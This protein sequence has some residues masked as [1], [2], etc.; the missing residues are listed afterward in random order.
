MRQVHQLV[1]AAVVAAA[2]TVAGVP[3]AATAEVPVG[4]TV[5]I[6]S[7]PEAASAGST[8]TFAFSADVEAT[9][10]CGL[11]GAELAPC[12]SPA[13]YAALAD[14]PHLFRVVATD[15]QGVVGAP[16]EVSWV[17]DT[18]APET[19]LVAAPPTPTESTTASFAFASTDAGAEFE[20]AVDGESFTACDGGTAAVGPLGDGSHTFAVRAAD[21]AGNVD[22]SPAAWKWTIDRSIV[23][24]QAPAVGATDV[25]PFTFV[26]VLFKKPMLASSFTTLTFTLWRS[27]GVQVP[28]SPSYNSSTGVATLAPVY[29]LDYSTTYRVRV[30]GVRT[31][32]G[33]VV[34]EPLSWPFTTTGT[35]VSRRINVGGPAYVGSDGNVWD[36]DSFVRGGVAETFWGAAIYGTSDPALYRDQRSALTSTS[37]W[38]YNGPLT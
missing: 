12:S 8:A 32:D 18:T 2:L 22:D 11:D 26:T 3:A 37:P 4:P 30:S 27:D 36:A 10:A 23:R 35:P 16:A 20:C 9:F 15:G 25:S 29:P 13:E 5:L 7:A 21:A 17:V 33:A 24:S 19:A 14:G 6:G 28:A 31:A 1:V 38:L 34:D